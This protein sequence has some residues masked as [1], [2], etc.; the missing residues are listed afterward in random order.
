M[1]CIELKYGRALLLEWH[2]NFN[3]MDEAKKIGN[4]MVISMVF[5][6]LPR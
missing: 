4:P 1:K 6:N 5:P 2:V 3:V